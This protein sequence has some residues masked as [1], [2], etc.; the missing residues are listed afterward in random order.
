MIVDADTVFASL[1]INVRQ[2]HPAL[3][4]SLHKPD[5]SNIRLID[6]HDSQKI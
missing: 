3:F 6:V 2:L 5:L 4:L 1:I